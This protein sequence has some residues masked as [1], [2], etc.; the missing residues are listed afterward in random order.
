MNVSFPYGAF[1]C[2]SNQAIPFIVAADP[3]K[4]KIRV[5]TSSAASAKATLKD[6]RLSWGVC[7][8]PGIAEEL[9]PNLKAES[10]WK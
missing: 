9:Q 8:K 10:K 2:G 1:Y 7:S 6:C 3:N 4:L 5:P